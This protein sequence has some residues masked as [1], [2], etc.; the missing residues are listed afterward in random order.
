M[1]ERLLAGRDPNSLIVLYVGRLAQE[2]RLDLLRKAA[3][4]DGIALTIV[5][6]GEE[7]PNLEAFFGE[8]A[9][10]TGYLFGEELAQ[11]YASAD[12]F[13]FTGTNETFGQVVTE[14]M[15]SGLPV[16][17]PNA[18]GVVD[19]VLD[20]MNGYICQVDPTDY[21]ARVKHI[22]DDDDLRQRLSQNAR[23][24]ALTRPWEA[25]MQRLETY[26]ERAW[27]LNEQ[28]IFDTPG[29][30]ASFEQNGAQRSGLRQARKSS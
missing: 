20:E 1:R 4:L 30:F 11:A 23:D 28:R 18:G 25:I 26:Y 21:E 10:F 24:Y 2:K 7:R 16:L 13:A 19:L 17:V 3:K 6:D 5:G 9:H 15:A 12:I 27:A 22:R 29:P 14:A 8:D